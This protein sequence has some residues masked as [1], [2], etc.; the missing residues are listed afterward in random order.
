MTSNNII[1]RAATVRATA[2]ATAGA[3]GLGV[4]AVVAYA[5]AAAT[6]LERF[7]VW[8]AVLLPPPGAKPAAEPGTVT[9]VGGGAA[10]LEE[11]TGSKQT[12][13]TVTVTNAPPGSVLPW[14]GN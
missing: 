2:Y 5:E 6:T 10:T 1:K 7:A 8:R 3:L 9:N 13:A 12:D 4:G 14:H 11:D